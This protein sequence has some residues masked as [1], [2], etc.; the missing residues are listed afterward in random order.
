MNKL[1]GKVALITGGNSGIGQAIAVE[2]AKQG[3]QVAIFGRNQSTL[4]STQKLVGNDTLAVQGDV[5]N[6]DDLDRLYKET[7]EQKGKIDVLV[8]NAGIAKPLP[9]E[10]TTEAFFDNTAD[11][12]FKGAFFTVQKA[13]PHLNDGAS[14]ILV[15]SIV[16]AKGF[17]GF[18]VYAAT[19]AAVRS[20]SRSWAAELSGRG[21]RVNTLS[22]GPIE[23]PIYDRMD[24][25]KEAMDGFA[26][27]MIQQVP[28]GRFGTSEEIAKAALFLASDDSSY[29]QGAELSVDGGIAQV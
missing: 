4:D 5:T 29:V 20:L 3:A 28:L 6:L 24:L 18:S 2:F 9:L 17:P 7:G 27:S 1:E 11:I 19:K 15:S 16:N 12:N 25:P 8:V 10:A 21:I 22:P 14:I 26:E 23:T 13:L